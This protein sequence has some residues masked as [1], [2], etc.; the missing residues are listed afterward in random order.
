MPHV[1]RS[2][3]GRNFQPNAAMPRKCGRDCA[4]KWHGAQPPVSTQLGRWTDNRAIPE[5]DVRHCV[6]PTASRPWQ[7]FHP[8]GF[9]PRKWTYKSASFRRKP[10]GNPEPEAWVV[11]RRAI[12]EVTHGAGIFPQRDSAKTA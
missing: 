3:F 7:S 2:P 6:A 11:A 9:A 10:V 4:G 1:S 12:Q 8:Q 5:A